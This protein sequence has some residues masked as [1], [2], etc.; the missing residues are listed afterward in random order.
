MVL[1]V[2]S[3][4]VSMAEDFLGVTVMPD[5]KVV[6]QSAERLEKTYD[7]SYD[8]AVA[9]YKDVLKDEKDIQFRDRGGVQMVIEEHGARLWHSVTITKVAE[10]KT[11]IVFVKDNWTWILGTLTLRFFGVF[12]VLIVLYIVLEISGAIISRVVKV[13]G[14]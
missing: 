12:A 6:N 2:L 5:G 10:G 4:C 14:T 13:E 3:P 8:A 9:F 7:V 1:W 11:D